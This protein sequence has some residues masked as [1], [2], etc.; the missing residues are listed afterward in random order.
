MTTYNKL[1]RDLIPEIIHQNGKN[2]LVKILS[3]EEYLKEVE[4]KMHEE[5]AEYVEAKN[6]DEKLEEFAD[7][8]ELLHTAA[9][10]QGISLE[11]L[12]ELRANKSEKHGGFA[13][14]IYLIEV[15]DN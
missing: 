3:N 12:E 14:R 2:P 1:V 5:L 6:N 4:R 13:K 8:L 7:L 9:N 11:K 10:I 15:L